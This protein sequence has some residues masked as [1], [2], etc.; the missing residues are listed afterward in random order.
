LASENI[1]GLHRAP[2][3]VPSLP[4]SASARHKELEQLLI[5]QMRPVLELRNRLAHGQWVYTLTNDQS[6]ISP[7]LMR[8][9]NIENALS[10][11]FK[12]QLLEHMAS[13]IHDLIVSPPTFDR[14][15]DHHFSLIVQ[16]RARIKRD[17]YVDWVS[18]LRAKHAEGRR[19]NRAGRQ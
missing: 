2:L 13:A 19:R 14:D 6:G 4:F 8:L 17:F 11:Q 9:L 1:R 7:E 3:E 5:E 15:F 12:Q 18:S 10:L 16:L